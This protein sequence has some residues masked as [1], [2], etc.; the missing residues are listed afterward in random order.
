MQTNEDSPELE[1]ELYEHFSFEVPKGQLLLRIDKFLMN[2]IPNATRNKIQQAAENGNILVKKENL[3]GLLNKKLTWIVP[4]LY[5]KI[6]NLFIVF[7]VNVF[8]VDKP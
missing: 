1:D 7:K 5:E 8:D 2:L 6:F 3:V 4:L